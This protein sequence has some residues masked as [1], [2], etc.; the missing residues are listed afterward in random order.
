MYLNCIHRLQIFYESVVKRIRK[1]NM[2]FYLI[3]KNNIFS[4]IFKLLRI[5][6]LHNNKN[7]SKH[8]KTTIFLHLL[9]SRKR[10]KSYLV[11]VFNIDVN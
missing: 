11:T 5:Q 10:H 9:L 2:Y 8:P 7:P 1:Q 4:T 3:I 6:N